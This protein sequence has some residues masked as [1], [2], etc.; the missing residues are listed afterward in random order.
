MWI[1][2][3]R[4]ASKDMPWDTPSPNFP[5]TLWFLFISLYWQLF[6]LHPMC[7]RLVSSA[8]SLRCFLTALHTCLEAISS[9]LMANV[10]I[11]FS[12]IHLDFPLNFRQYIKSLLN[13]PIWLLTRNSKSTSTPIPY[14]RW[15]ITLSKK[16]HQ[17]IV[18]RIY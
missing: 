1:I 2:M 13:I 18:I 9:I 4:S 8:L 14:F 10:T 11:S 15:L 12:P 17:R 7:K 16:I 5:H 3:S 6:L